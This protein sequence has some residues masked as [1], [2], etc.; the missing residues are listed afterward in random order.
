MAIF[1]A[2]FAF[3]GDQSL[4]MTRFEKRD[5]S[6]SFL[7]EEAGICAYAQLDGTIDLA[8]AEEALKTVEKSASQYVIGSVGL[9]GYDESHDVHIY[10]DTDGWI[11]A[12]YLADEKASK[13]VNWVSFAESGSLM[14]TKIRVALSYV[15]EQML[16]FP[17]D[18][19][20]YDFRYPDATKM[21]IVADEEGSSGTETFRIKIPS[22]FSVYSRTWS[23]Y[24]TYSSNSIAIDGVVLYEGSGI[25]EGDLTV[26]Q[27][28]PDEYH[29]VSIY[30]HWGDK[31]YGAIMLIYKE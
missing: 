3:A 6:T 24:G 12:Y 28:S 20:H 15:C 22:D 7:H 14:E 26:S 21:M 5:G 31:D 11:I 23:Y 30:H 19:K 10:V 13:I 27:L 4:D 17:S 29:E 9:E 8:K 16:L 25:R 18:I 1:V 2:G